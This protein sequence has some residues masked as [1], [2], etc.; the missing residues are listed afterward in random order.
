MMFFTKPFWFCVH[1]QRHVHSGVK[2]RGILRPEIFFFSS[3]PKKKK[4]KETSCKARDPLVYVDGLEAGLKP[5]GQQARAEESIFKTCLFQ[6]FGKISFFVWISSNYFPI[7]A[8]DQL[9]SMVS[10]KTTLG[11]AKHCHGRTTVPP[12][13]REGILPRSQHSSWMLPIVV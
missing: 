1:L 9:I 4:K 6:G 11:S 12:G 8:P 2:D 10:M 3:P 13:E 7:S 5:G